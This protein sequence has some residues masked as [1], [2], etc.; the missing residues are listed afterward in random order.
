[1]TGPFMADHRRYMHEALN[2]MGA[3]LLGR[4]TYEI[5]AQ[6]WPTV[7][8]PGDEIARMLNAVPKYVASTAMRDGVWSE[9]TVI[10]DVPRQVRELKQEPGKDIFV[11]GSSLLA[12]SLIND[13]LIDEYRLMIHPVVL[14]TGKR[15]FRE[16]APAE[17]LRRID[18]ITTRSARHTHLR[19]GGRRSV[20][21]FDRAAS[22]RACGLR[23]E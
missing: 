5:W 21:G 23:P 14:G 19:T 4:I 16:G 20:I 3:L 6:Y 2:A 22:T 10:D 18:A 1:R 13:Q 7:T 17:T 11:M 15:L 8:D 9:T 12:Q